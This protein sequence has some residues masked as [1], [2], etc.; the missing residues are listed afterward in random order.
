MDAMTPRV[1]SYPPAKEAPSRSSSGELDRTAKRLCFPR[2]SRPPLIASF[3]ASV[4]ARP[5]TAAFIASQAP[6]SSAS[7]AL[8][9]AAQAGKRL[10][11]SI[12]G[13][14]NETGSTNPG[15]TGRPAELARMSES[16]FPPT[17]ARVAEASPGNATTALAPASVAATGRGPA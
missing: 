10:S 11:S 16:P 8:R 7:E 5:P 1:V 17:S 6:A 9:N 15:G 3:W 13:A 2:R 14:K 4:K 12:Q